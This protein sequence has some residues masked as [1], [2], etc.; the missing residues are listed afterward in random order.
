[1]RV[2]QRFGKQYEATKGPLF[3]CVHLQGLLECGY[4]TEDPFFVQ[5]KHAEAIW[6][7]QRRHG[8]TKPHHRLLGRVLEGHTDEA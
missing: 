4:F 7:W 2:K 5:R 6:A 1:M 8:D 3:F